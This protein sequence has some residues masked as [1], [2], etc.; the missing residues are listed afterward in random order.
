MMIIAKHWVSTHRGKRKEEPG[1]N[2]FFWAYIEFFCTN[3]ITMYM[4]SKGSY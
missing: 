3:C 4:T 2:S 1:K